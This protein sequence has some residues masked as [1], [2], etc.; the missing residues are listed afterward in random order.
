M[1]RGRTRV[2]LETSPRALRVPLRARETPAVSLVAVALAAVPTSFGF[3]VAVIVAREPLL[4]KRGAAVVFSSTRREGARDARRGRI[5]G[6]LFSIKSAPIRA[7]T[8][9]AERPT[10]EDIVAAIGMKRKRD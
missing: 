6:C 7:K 2:A 5:N 4:S 9:G 1:K 8:V 3:P 10:F